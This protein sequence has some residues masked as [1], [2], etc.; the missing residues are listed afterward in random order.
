VLSGRAPPS[1]GK[2]AWV[3][4]AKRAFKRVR[5]SMLCC[6]YQPEHNKP[7]GKCHP[8]IAKGAAGYTCTGETVPL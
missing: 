3:R 6:F 2:K 5:L 4:R 8:A 1:K 7:W